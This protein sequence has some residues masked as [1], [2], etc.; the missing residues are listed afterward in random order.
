[1]AEDLLTTDEAARLLSGVTAGQL[2]IW[3]HRGIGP[4][5]V[6]IDRRGVRYRRTELEA[7]QRTRERTV[8]PSGGRA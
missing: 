4:A 8:A 5:Y 1:M 6:K 3:R 2:A 7:Y